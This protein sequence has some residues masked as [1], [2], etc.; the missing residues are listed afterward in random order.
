MA[1]LYLSIKNVHSVVNLYVFRLSYTQKTYIHHSI[2]HMTTFFTI[3][4]HGYTDQHY[5]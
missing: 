3:T 4:T 1:G 5:T 2:Q